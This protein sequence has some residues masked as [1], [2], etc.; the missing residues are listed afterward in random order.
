MGGELR[1]VCRRQVAGGLEGFAWPHRGSLDCPGEGH[2]HAI[3]GSQQ[4]ATRGPQDPLEWYHL[5]GAYHDSLCYTLCID[6]C[7]FLT[8]GLWL[9]VNFLM[10][11]SRPLR[12]V[13][14]CHAP[15]L[16][17]CLY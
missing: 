16:H 6:P 4:P 8:W 13:S 14:P 9:N 1:G 5:L 17:H 10:E 2:P 12:Q 7:S 11:P 3:P 15:T